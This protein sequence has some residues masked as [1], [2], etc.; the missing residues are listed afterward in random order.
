VDVSLRAWHHSPSLSLLNFLDCFYP[1]PSGHR[2][3]HSLLIRLR[4][5]PLFCASPLRAMSFC[6]LNWMEEPMPL[7]IPA[8]QV[9]PWILLVYP[10]PSGHLHQFP[11]NDMALQ[12]I[13][14]CISIFSPVRG[15]CVAPPVLSL[16]IEPFQGPTCV[17]SALVF[18]L[19]PLPLFQCLPFIGQG[20]FY[21]S[22]P[23]YLSLSPC[24]L[25][26]FPFDPNALSNPTSS[27]TCCFFLSL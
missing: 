1:P 6:P 24:S 19:T 14:D 5:P 20:F 8:A 18:Y 25:S 11:S 26:H 21:E 4:G 10:S 16:L 9:F 7:E 17:S 15:Q 13:I 2:C 22:P 12:E 23:M 3:H 27:S